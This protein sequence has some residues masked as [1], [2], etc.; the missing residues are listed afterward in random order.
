MR[1]KAEHLL[2]ILH[3][4]RSVPRWYRHISFFQ[5][6]DNRLWT[7]LR[8]ISPIW[9]S[10]VV[11]YIWKHIRCNKTAWCNHATKTQLFCK[12]T[13]PIVSCFKITLTPPLVYFWKKTLPPPWLCLGCMLA[14]SSLVAPDMPHY[15]LPHLVWDGVADFLVLKNVTT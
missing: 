15:I 1:Q 12:T 10:Y 8:S 13:L 6:G 11:L 9:V 14:P 3:W 5:I 4:V 7:C 2:F